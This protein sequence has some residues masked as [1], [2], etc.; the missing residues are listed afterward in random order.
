MPIVTVFGIQVGFFISGAVITE[1]VFAIPGMGT[2]LWRSIL[3]RDYLVTQSLILVGIV[4]FVVVSLLTDVAYA[5]LD[6]RIR[7]AH[8]VTGDS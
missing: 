3:T 5:I 6:P 8:G 4:G 1:A 7:Y 2:A